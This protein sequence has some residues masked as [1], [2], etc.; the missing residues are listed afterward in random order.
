LRASTIQRCYTILPSHNLFGVK[1]EIIDFWANLGVGR[2]GLKRNVDLMTIGT[3]GM[4]RYY[5]QLLT[6]RSEAAVLF[7]AGVN[8][9]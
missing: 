1:A 9:L 2:K 8:L 6:I 3:T 5:A 7:N 4:H